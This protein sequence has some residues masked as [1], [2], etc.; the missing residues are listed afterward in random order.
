[1]KS[2]KSEACLKHVM[3]SISRPHA[4]TIDPLGHLVYDAKNW[5]NETGLVK[6]KFLDKYIRAYSHSECDTCIV[7][8]GNHRIWCPEFVELEY[9][10][11]EIKC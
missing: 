1:M 9:E 2:L 3:G 4:G 6:P 5:F 10:E 8:D 11:E 7:E